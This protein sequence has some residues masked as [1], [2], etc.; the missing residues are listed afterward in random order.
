M[1]RKPIEEYLKD[2]AYKIAFA[3]F[4]EAMEGIVAKR[5]GTVERDDT[6]RG[7]L[8]DGPHFQYHL[9]IYIAH[10]ICS[11]YLTVVFP[12]SA[13]A[14]R[15]VVLVQPI[16]PLTPHGNNAIM[17]STLPTPAALPPDPSVPSFAPL[18]ISLS[19]TS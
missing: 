15:P 10:V 12:L 9:C 16:S 11:I 6:H 7:P 17:N 19:V 4:R 18:S 1:R 2:E 5:G 13:A 8:I 14:V 3:E